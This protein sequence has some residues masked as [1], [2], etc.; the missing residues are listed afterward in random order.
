MSEQE[1]IHNVLI[2]NDSEMQSLGTE[3]QKRQWKIR[4]S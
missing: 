1:L 3:S 2:Q 4:Q